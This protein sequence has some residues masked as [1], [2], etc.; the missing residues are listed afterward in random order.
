MTTTS[1]HAEPLDVADDRELLAE[2][3]EFYRDYLVPE[4]VC[5]PRGYPDRPSESWL[6]AEGRDVLGV[7]DEYDDGR[8]IGMWVVKER[9]IYFPCI[10]VEWGGEPGLVAIFRALTELSVERHGEAMS[11]STSN[12]LILRWASQMGMPELAV[13]ENRLE[14]QP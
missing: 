3:V 11:A 10:D 1:M 14:W 7:R 9:G 12:Q 6:W 4:L 5:G 2:V 8:L 13:L